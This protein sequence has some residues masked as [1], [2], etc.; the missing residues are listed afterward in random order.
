MHLVFFS[1][2][3]QAHFTFLKRKGRY[4]KTSHWKKIKESLSSKSKR[5]IIHRGEKEANAEIR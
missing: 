5:V 2:T 1:L 4:Y 3:L